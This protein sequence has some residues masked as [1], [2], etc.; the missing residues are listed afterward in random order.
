MTETKLAPYSVY[1][2]STPNPSTLK[3]VANRPIIENNSTIEYTDPDQTTGAPLAEKIFNFP[4]VT[5][6]FFAG[7]FIT[8]TKNDLVEWDDV[9]LELREFIQDQLNSGEPFFSILPQANSDITKNSSEENFIAVK[10]KTTI[11]KQIVDILEE[12]IMPAVANDGGAINFKSFEDGKLT[13]V[14]RGSCS[15]C[16]SST[17]TLKQGIQTLMSQMVPEVK[18]VVSEDL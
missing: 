11:E 10:P 12:Y 13:V 17:V 6:L 5:N 2:E 1:A 9:A 7:N 16:P 4:F 3:F 14:M 8:V 18:E 15:G